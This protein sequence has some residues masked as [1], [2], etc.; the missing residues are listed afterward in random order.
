MSHIDYKTKYIKYK[1]KYLSLKEESGGGRFNSELYKAIKKYR[2]IYN[3]WEKEANEKLKEELK[4]DV[5]VAEH[6]LVKALYDSKSFKTFLKKGFDDTES[7][8]A[9]LTIPDVNPDIKY[10]VIVNSVYEKF[11]KELLIKKKIINDD[12]QNVSSI[13]IKEEFI[14]EL[15]K[16]LMSKKK[17]EDII[18]GTVILKLIQLPLTSNKN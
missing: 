1:T 18:A 5:S 15:N 6:V 3:K 17:V 7:F 2:N 8:T 10:T 16:L 9:F 14:N 12:T 4:K 11:I 13:M